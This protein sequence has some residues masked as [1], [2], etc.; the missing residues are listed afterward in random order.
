MQISMSEAAR[1]N[2]KIETIDPVIRVGKR[3][4]P[5][6]SREELYDYCSTALSIIL[7]DSYVDARQT[8]LLAHI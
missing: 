2:R 3:L 5:L 8:T 7:A 4:Y 1:R 6:L